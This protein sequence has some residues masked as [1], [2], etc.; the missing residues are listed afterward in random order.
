MT[1]IK[2]VPST[3]VIGPHGPCITRGYTDFGNGLRMYEDQVVVGPCGQHQISSGWTE[4][5]A[6]DE[7]AEST[8]TFE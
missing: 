4:I 1:K 8:N 3:V 2:F 5:V 6:S 7:A